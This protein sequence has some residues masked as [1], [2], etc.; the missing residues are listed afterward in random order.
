MSND[1]ST[2]T[3]TVVDDVVRRVTDGA[4]YPGLAEHYAP[5]VLLDMN[6]PTWRFQLQ[7]RE[8][9]TK[10]FEEQLPGADLRCTHAR[11]DRIADGVVVESEIRFDG[12]GG[13]Y[14]WRAIDVF[15]FDGDQITEHVEYCSGCWDPATVERHGREA[16]MVRW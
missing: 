11:V 12:D 4:D 13:E 3:D 2:I 6:L 8:A 1:T 9:V 15:R 5:D 14:L 16:P 10:Y 7:G